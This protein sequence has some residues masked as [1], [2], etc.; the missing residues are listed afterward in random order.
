M[1]SADALTHGPTGFLPINLDGFHS[2]RLAAVDASRLPGL[3]VHPW[4]AGGRGLVFRRYGDAR[5]SHV[6]G[7]RIV[8]R[9]HLA[10]R[11]LGG[12]RVVAYKNGDPLDCR[13]TNLLSQLPS[14]P[15]PIQ[16]GVVVSRLDGYQDALAAL[17]DAVFVQQLKAHARGRATPSRATVE[18]TRAFLE[19][20]FTMPV[21]YEA[22]L[23]D[24]AQRFSDQV[25]HKYS[26][27]QM[28]K[29]LQGRSL[30]VPGFDYARLQALRPS[31]SDRARQREE[32]FRMFG[33]YGRK[34][35][36]FS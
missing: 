29:I 6:A 32:T 13:A 10:S 19:E 35:R 20:L 8:Q 24:L 12:V 16:P 25:G 34:P 36:N 28:H 9:E 4:H 30:H 33:D 22:R 18:Q 5:A 2:F 1:F 21:L 3:L 11:I 27:S 23:H 31:L 15:A 14:T 17:S 26:A 7:H